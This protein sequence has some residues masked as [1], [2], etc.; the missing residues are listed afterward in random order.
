MDALKHGMSKV[1][2]KPDPN[3][4]IWQ[5]GIPVLIVLIA[6]AYFVIGI[7]YQNTYGRYHSNQE[8]INNLLSIRRYTLG[9]AIDPTQ[10]NNKSVCAQILAKTGPYARI[11]EASSLIVNWRPLTVRMAG[12]LGGDI[13][14]RDGVFDMQKGIQLAMHVGARAFVF[15]IDYLEVKP[16]EPVLIHRDQQGY[17]RSLH[18][19][20]IRDGMDALTRYSF[21]TNYDPVLVIIYLRRIPRGRTQKDIFFK[22]LAASLDPL[23]TFH[24]GTT[25]QGNFHNC[26]SEKNLFTSEIT[27][28]QKKFIVMCNYNTNLLTNTPN[29][30]DNLDFWTN[31]RIYLDE[32]GKANTLGEVTDMV[33]NGQVPYAQVGATSQLLQIPPDSQENFIIK[34]SNTF[35]IALGT[36]GEVLTP[37]EM[38]VLLSTLGVHCIP[39]DVLRLADTKEHLE[40]LKMNSECNDLR[41]LAQLTNPSDPLSFWRFAG[42]SRKYIQEGFENPNIPLPEPIPGFIKPKSVVP[43]KPPI[44]TN[45]NGGLVNIS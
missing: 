30:K 21:N 37:S 27:N 15:D 40:T 24:L 19:G 26:R 28:F 10:M 35:K 42:W 29:P 5:I 34:S 14:A 18:T 38:A 31:A 6:I 44:S 36:M 25:E 3:G 43:T 8:S 45:S 4:V 22:A 32:N 23:S 1:G 13:T 39:I 17:M 9:N 41:A 2:V 11:T 20:S 33:P 16:C 12:Y 7:G